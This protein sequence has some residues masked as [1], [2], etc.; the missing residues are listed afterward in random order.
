MTKADDYF[1][2]RSFK[3][4]LEDKTKIPLGPGRCYD[5]RDFTI[6]IVTFL[7]PGLRSSCPLISYFGSNFENQAARIEPGFQ[8]A[9]IRVNR[10]AGECGVRVGMTKH[11]ISGGFGV[12]ESHS[13]K[14]KFSQPLGAEEVEPL[15]PK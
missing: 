8:N 4:K 6:T 9:L 2:D 15:P 3:L 1:W 5:Y 10:F 14:T 13:F 12:L 11:R 7:I